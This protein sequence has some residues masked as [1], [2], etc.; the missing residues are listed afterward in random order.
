MANYPPPPPGGGWSPPPGAPIDPYAHERAFQAWAQARGVTI[1][2]AADVRWYASWGP[3]VYLP[4]FQRVGREARAPISPPPAEAQAFV[5]ETIDSD[6][7]RQATGDDRLLVAFVTSARL[8]YRAA[9]RSKSGGASALDDFARGLDA[10]VSAGPTPGSALGDPTFERAF[11]V[12]APTREE[13]NAALP[14]PLRQALLQ[15]G[16]R[17]VLELRPGGMICALYDR[18]S[19]DPTT[20]DGLLGTTAHLHGLATQYAVMP[21]RG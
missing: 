17:G 9:I 16:F 1:N 11:D 10:L 18:R 19:F 13:G 4:A 14:I 20:L 3:F 12:G 8:A 5:V 15:M 7:I 2:P 6:P 21:A